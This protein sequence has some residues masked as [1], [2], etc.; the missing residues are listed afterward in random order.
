MPEFN[1][2]NHHEVL[3]AYR[4]E[5]VDNTALAQ[6]LAT[7]NNPRKAFQQEFERAVIRWCSG[8]YEQDY[9][10]S[11]RQ[12]RQRCAFGL[13]QIRQLSQ[14]HKTI[15]IF[16]SGGPIAS[17]AGQCLGLNDVRVAE[18]SWSVI[19]GSVTSLLT[20]KDKLSLRCFNDFSHLEYNRSPS[21]IS[22][23]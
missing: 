6:W 9:T 21:L 18:L 19:N 8:E 1:E 2:Y 12:F 23:R 20:T 16:T 22:H 13:S 11:W 15:A 17:M 3:K 14:Q 10:E 4:P 7:N 5:L